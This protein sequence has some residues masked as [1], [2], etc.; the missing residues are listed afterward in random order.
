MRRMYGMFTY[1][2]H[3]FMVNVGF[4]SIHSA[5]VGLISS[6]IPVHLYQ[7][8]LHKCFRSPKKKN[9]KGAKGEGAYTGAST[10]SHIRSAAYTASKGFPPLRNVG[11]SNLMAILLR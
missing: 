8:S 6:C 7:A 2:W 3:K 10:T 1:M 4:Y 9:G 11:L 5:H